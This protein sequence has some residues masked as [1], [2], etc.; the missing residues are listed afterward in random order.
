MK[1]IQKGEYQLVFFTPEILL[2]KKQWRSMLTG[3]VYSRRLRALVVDEAHT[4]RSWL[5]LNK[6]LQ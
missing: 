1:L 4:V 3:E 6:F 2:H 5:V